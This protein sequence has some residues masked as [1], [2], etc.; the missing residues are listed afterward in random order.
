MTL[1]THMQGAML[2]GPEHIETWIVL[3][4]VGALALAPVP[5]GAFV[6]YRRT[7]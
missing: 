7:R 3:A 2:L 6:A 5:T 1:P 4:S